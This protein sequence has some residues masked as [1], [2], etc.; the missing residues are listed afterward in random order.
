MSRRATAVG[1]ARWLGLIALSLSLACTRT[2]PSFDAGPRSSAAPPNEST[3]FDAGSV[4][5]ATDAKD[6]MVLPETY[7]ACL[8]PHAGRFERCRKETTTSEASLARCRAAHAGDPQTPDGF[9]VGR[10][11][12]TAFS[13][14]RRRCLTF[15]AAGSLRVEIESLGS[16][17]VRAISDCAART[18][19][20]TEANYGGTIATRCSRRDAGSDQLLA[21]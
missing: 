13:P 16:V 10:G 20:V 6:A 8:H 9:R 7:R 1:R 11:G 18:I 4:G 15:P 19:D 14:T 2:D 3:E 12:W 21:E 5:T 17:V